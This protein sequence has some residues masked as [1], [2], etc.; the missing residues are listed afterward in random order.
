MEKEL[1]EKA[2]SDYEA[3]E[4]KRYEINLRHLSNGV[5]FID[6]KA[7][8]IDETVE[9]GNG[10]VIY[11]GVILEGNTVIGENCIIGQNTRAVD[12]IIGNGTEVQSSVILESKV[13]NDTK[14]GP[15]AYLRPH[16]TIGNRVKVGDFVEIKNS[17]LGDGSKAPHL[18][19]IGDADVGEK[20]N[21]GCGVVF[22]NY[23][24]KNKHRSVVKDGAFVGC[25]VNLVSPVIVEEGAYIAAG[26]T[27]THDVPKEALCVGR[28]KE[29]N[30]EGWVVRRG[31]LNKK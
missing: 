11:P 21:L 30:I 14:V 9:I 1:M 2:L 6:L 5:R 10:T 7:A 18:T 17:S 15:F 16:S 27:V 22:V 24:G 26:T 13:G 23:D 12:S 31:L 19:Y 8:Y 25:N 3:Q 29:K 20:V 4:R 28:T